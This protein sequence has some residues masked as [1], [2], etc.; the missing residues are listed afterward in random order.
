M[1]VNGGVRDND[2]YVLGGLGKERAGDWKGEEH[3]ITPVF[4]VEDE[5]LYYDVPRRRDRVLRPTP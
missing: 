1:E 2:G 3:G 4:G 5:G